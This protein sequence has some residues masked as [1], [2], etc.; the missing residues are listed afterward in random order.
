M[1]VACTQHDAATTSQR[2]IITN[3]YGVRDL[4]VKTIIVQFERLIN[5]LM[6]RAFLRIYG[7]YLTFIMTRFYVNVAGSKTAGR[8]PNNVRAH[9]PAALESRIKYTRIVRRSWVGVKK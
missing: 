9:T 5:R 6:N 2:T 4:S 8:V 3:G 1:I 7:S